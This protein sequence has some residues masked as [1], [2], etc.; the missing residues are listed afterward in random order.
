MRDKTTTS[1]RLP[2]Y[3]PR[4]A[5]SGALVLGALL[6]AQAA[7]VTNPFTPAGHV[8][9]VY[10]EPRT[11]GDGG[12]RG[13]LKGPGSFGG[14]LKRHRVVNI[15]IRPATYAAS[16]S[17]PTA[18][19]AIDVEW[20]ALLHPDP[21]SVRRVVEEFGSADWYERH[22]APIVL[23]QMRKAVTEHATHSYR[24]EALEQEALL[25]VDAALAELELPFVIDSLTVRSLRAPA[26]LVAD[27]H[28]AELKPPTP[29]T[30][31]VSPAPLTEGPEP[32]DGAT[33]I[34]VS[35]R[36]EFRGMWL[37]TVSNVDWPSREGL[38]A[39]K[40]K[41]EL[42]TYLD[43]LRTMNINALIFQVRPASDAFYPSD[44][45]PWSRWLTGEAGKDPGYD[46][47]QFAIDECRKRSMEFHAWFN[48]FRGMPVEDFEVPGTH[49]TKRLSD[50][51]LP[52]ASM[53]WMDP[54]AKAVRDH[55]TSVVLDVVSRYEIDG[56]HL[57]D[58]FYPYPVRGAKL[59]DGPSY[60]RYVEEW[61]HMEKDD[62]RRHNIDSLIAGLSTG[63]R[64]IKPHM[65]FGISPFGLYRPGEPFGTRGLDQ[66]EE[67]YSDPKKWMEKGWIDYLTP[68]LYWK[69]NSNRSYSKL[70]EWWGESNALRRHIYAGN[71]LLS[72]ERNKGN[73]PFSEFKT[74][75]E[76]SREAFEFQSLGNIFFGLRVFRGKSGASVLDRFT[77]DLYPTQALPPAMP[78]LSNRPPRRPENVHAGNTE[79]RWDSAASPAVKHWTLY[80]RD[81]E[82]G[83]WELADI[84]PS[85]T[86]RVDAAPGTYALCA[87]DRL[88]QES[89]GVLVTVAAPDISPS[90]AAKAEEPAVAESDPHPEDTE[91]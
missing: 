61:G 16:A 83:C 56:V 17:V 20:E 46:P 28:K 70:L 63:I 47:L 24:C 25:A 42:V 19:G 15:D 48:P 32:D 10:E 54:G 80:A 37:A 55:V 44:L 85:S 45:E 6:L 34:E 75:L 51:A 9:Y 62:W 69:E 84:L 86:T 39:D 82:D 52:Y 36:R 1:A 29:A 30:P 89:I 35:H 53:V 2:T 77:S 49:I 87:C 14:S 12:F 18:E 76:A 67:I 8:G 68:Q 27:A 58:Y 4:L 7:L 38:P 88:M 79:I 71:N 81:A 74:Q 26:S 33:L 11:F 66:F 91:S 41:A 60:K 78:W 21:D 22:V 57:D 3:L 13:L 50:H 43:Q 90:D 23:G 5:I 40:Q 72:I 65:K 73:W 31:A 64:A 59:D